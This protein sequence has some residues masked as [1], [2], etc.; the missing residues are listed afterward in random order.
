MQTCTLLVFFF[1][2]Y[3]L[4]FCVNIIMCCVISIL[5]KVGAI[6]TSLSGDIIMVLTFVSATSCRGLNFF[7]LHQWLEASYCAVQ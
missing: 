7:I 2:W 6:V 3:Q 4:W 5:E 1:L